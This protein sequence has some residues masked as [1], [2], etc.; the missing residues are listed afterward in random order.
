MQFYDWGDL[1]TSARSLFPVIYL[2]FLAPSSSVASSHQG[3]NS[4]QVL[5]NQ[6]FSFC[7]FDC[8][9]VGAV[10]C[11]VTQLMMDRKQFL[12]FEMAIRCTSSKFFVIDSSSCRRLWLF[13]NFWKFNGVKSVYIW[14][15]F[16]A[17]ELISDTIGIFLL[18]PVRSII[19]QKFW[20]SEYKKKSRHSYCLISLFNTQI[21][22]E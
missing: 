21:I 17:F 16:P 10:L 7:L 1:C 6:L 5:C 2:R 22:L 19:H 12:G 18:L 9:F 8:C 14:F 3:N 15:L 11:R 13:S 20:L 4:I